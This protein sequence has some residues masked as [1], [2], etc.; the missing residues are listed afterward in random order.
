MW[1]VKN[2][3]VDI[4]ETERYKNP[5][6]RHWAFEFRAARNRRMYL[7]DN[8]SMSGN[9]MVSDLQAKFMGLM[10]AADMSMKFPACRVY[11]PRT[12]KAKQTSTHRAKHRA[13]QTST[14]NKQKY[15]QAI[16]KHTKKH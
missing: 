14:Q 12:N 4:M 11:T 6:D 3:M 15:K 1:D 7:S 9:Q 2:A 8:M 10:A 5:G 16:N 13:K